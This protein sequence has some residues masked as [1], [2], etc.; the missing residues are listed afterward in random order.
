MAIFIPPGDEEDPTR[1][2]A[3]YDET[4]DYLAGIGIPVL[5]A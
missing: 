2:P 4:F 1:P 3:F 5:G